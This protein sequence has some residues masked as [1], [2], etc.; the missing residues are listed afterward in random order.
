MNAILRHLILIA[1]VCVFLEVHADVTKPNES[2]QKHKEDT[3]D[4]YL[5]RMKSV[6]EKDDRCEFAV[7]SIPK[8]RESKF[9][10]PHSAAC[11]GGL[12]FNAGTM[13][14]KT[15]C[16]AFVLDVD[17]LKISPLMDR[18]GY[19]VAEG[20]GCRS[21]GFESVIASTLLNDCAMA[22]NLG[23]NFADMK[24]KKIPVAR[25]FAIPFII[26]SNLLEQKILFIYHGDQKYVDWYTKESTQFLADQKV[27]NKTKPEGK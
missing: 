25:A 21:G 6:I 23:K 2:S 16:T 7:V 11:V 27:G 24:C 22:S 20:K 1:S 10:W 17:N 4:D 18:I 14:E 19:N 12:T 26:P 13:Q 3:L 5:A 9:L 8:K 15:G